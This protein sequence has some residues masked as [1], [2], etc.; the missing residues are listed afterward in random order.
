MVSPFPKIYR[1][2]I[3]VVFLIVIL[4]FTLFYH[5]QTV[6]ENNLRT[7]MLNDQIDRQRMATKTLSQ[8]IGSDLSLVVTVLDG[9][10]SSVYFQN[11]ATYSVEQSNALMSEKY[12]TLGDIIDKMFVLD[13][14][15]IVIAGLSQDGLEKNL[16]ADFSQRAWVKEVK[17]N[18]LPAFSNGFERQGTFSIYI[19]VPIINSQSGKYDGLIGASIPT[20]RFFGRYGNV[21]DINSQFLVAFDKNGTIL[22]V[23]ADRS[24]VGKNF[25]GATVQQFIHHNDY[26]NNLT[27][28]L[29]NGNSV[30][31]M[32]D[33]G[34]TER[35]NTGQPIF[36][37]DEPK[38]YVQIVTPTNTVLS[39]ISET[40]VIERIKSY[41]LLIGVLASVACLILF[42]LKWNNTI[43]MEVVRR[44]ED[45]NK[46]NIE[47]NSVSRRL[48][49]SNLSLDSAN[50]QL[51]RHEK[52]QQ[53]FINMAAHELRTPIQPILGLADVLRD[54]ISDSGRAK[55]LNVI[56]RNAKRLQRLSS[57]LLDV[58]KIEGSALKLSKSQFDL[59]EKIENT[60]NDIENS[61]DVETKKNVKIIFRSS[62]PI[63]IF[64]D[65]DRI[66]Q[67]LSNLFNNAVKF[68]GNGIVTVGATLSNSP[69]KQVIVT[70]TDTGVGISPEI[71]P[72]LF[73]KFVTTSNQGTGLG[74]FISKGII[75]AHG[76][77]IWAENNQSGMG[78]TFSFSLPL[79]QP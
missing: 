33:Y 71:M 45:L 54:S 70:V 59:T 47:L 25:F 75:E 8:H 30:N 37:K 48:K 62:G 55:L 51:K 15:D 28:N 67:V 78:S 79:D 32:Y 21:H 66:F 4:S 77:R 29:L 17:Q 49:T 40:L 24:L 34:R 9:M 14:N 42:L 20:E 68:T 58:S 3:L 43:E 31:G 72:K 13:K 74:L 65:R 39:K 38:Y 26:L 52:M 44:T 76:G 5:I 41:S 16:G 64:A 6:T 69:N 23:G 61:F 2:G 7:N 53:E 27:R 56:M 63:S 22:A 50:A 46:I 10:T 36:V 1:V 19:A 73:S 18:L 60:I 35:I 57:D 11:E 12:A